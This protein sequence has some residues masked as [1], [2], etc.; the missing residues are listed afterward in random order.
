M[1]PVVSGK[2]AR[3]A[4]EKAGW[5]F[6]RQRGSHMILSKTGFDGILS[7]PD[8]AELDRGTLRHLIRA[9]GLTVD[10]FQSLLK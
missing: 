10:E 7:V 9:S 2:V 1:L 8:H 3:K 4:L 6:A 5:V